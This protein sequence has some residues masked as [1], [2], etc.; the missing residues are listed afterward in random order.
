MSDSSSRVCH[1]TNTADIRHIV[2][3]NDDAS[4]EQPGLLGAIV[5]ALYGDVGMPVR[6]LSGCVRSGVHHSGDILA[7]LLRQRVDAEWPRIH[8]SACPTK[9]LAKERAAAQLV[10]GDLLMP[11]ERTLICHGSSLVRL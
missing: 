10:R 6:S 5:D 4:A 9:E 3:W 7:V 2:R 8:F 1:R 11:N